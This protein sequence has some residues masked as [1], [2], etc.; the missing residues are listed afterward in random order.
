MLSLCVDG[1][2]SVSVSGLEENTAREF[3]FE[4]EPHPVNS[5]AQIPVKYTFLKLILGREFADNARSIRKSFMEYKILSAY[6]WIRLIAYSL[7]M[8]EIIEM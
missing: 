6:F 5:N 7:D 8:I 3:S 4:E 2:R 1:G